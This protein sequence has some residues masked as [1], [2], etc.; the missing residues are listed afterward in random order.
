[1]A[2]IKIFKGDTPPILKRGEW[3]TNHQAVY[4]GGDDKGHKMF[5]GVFNPE[6]NQNINGFAYDADSRSITIPA[7]TPLIKVQELLDNLPRSVKSSNNNDENY[8]K[9][10]FENSLDESDDTQIYKYDAETEF[11]IKDFNN[12]RLIF[13]SE[14]TDL[15]TPY[16]ILQFKNRGVK[17]QNSKLDF[18]RM[19]FS[20]NN[21][22]TPLECL[23]DISN[24]QI[25]FSR[26]RYDILHQKIKYLFSLQGRS[27]IYLLNQ[28]V[29]TANSDEYMID[30]LFRQLDVTSISYIKTDSSYR[31]FNH[32]AIRKPD[33][34]V[35]TLYGDIR[36][37]DDD[38]AESYY[39]NRGGGQLIESSG[40]HFSDR[41][42]RLIKS[43]NDTVNQMSQ[44]DFVR[45]EG[46]MGSLMIELFEQL[47][48]AGFR[49]VKADRSGI[50]FIG[51]RNER[52][53]LYFDGRGV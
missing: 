46:N 43:Q 35:E 1:M 7:G 11:V 21:E 6:V 26:T 4:L 34:I 41:L 33:Y 52:F 23:F 39:R 10:L 37:G 28:L 16:A 3:A 14:S 9:L 24:S 32:R 12:Y 31:N 8:L 25:E 40:I 53:P 18:V 44:N 50:T 47:A 42:S 15:S 27:V 29:I 30:N 19:K 48:K 36:C 13:E 5:Q 20:Y 51:R 49:R 38:I 22:T 45:N 17:I 2:T